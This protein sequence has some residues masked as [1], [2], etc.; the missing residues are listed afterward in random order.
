VGYGIGYQETYDHDDH[1]GGIFPSCPECC[2]QKDE[3][4][5]RY[6]C[7]GESKFDC[8]LVGDYYDKLNSKAKEEEKVEF[9]KRD[10][11]LTATLAISFF[12]SDIK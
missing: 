12:N 8:C 9:Q 11:N 3:D 1:T 4:R 6:C 10:V 5:D 7:Q 2:H